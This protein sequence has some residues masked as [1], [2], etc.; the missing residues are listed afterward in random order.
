MTTAVINTETELEIVTSD[1]NTDSIPQIDGPSES[2]TQD[3]K[4]VTVKNKEE[5]VV[6]RCKKTV[7]LRPRR[8][9]LVEPPGPELGI[10]SDPRQ[11]EWRDKVFIEYVFEVDNVQMELYRVI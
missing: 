2:Q 9:P 5:P 7:M 8:L 10:G 11:T 6:V 1:T 3:V 4:Q